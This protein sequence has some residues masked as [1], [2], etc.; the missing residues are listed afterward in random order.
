MRR[1]AFGLLLGSSLLFGCTP[2]APAPT[3]PAAP[4]GG[5]APTSG[6]TSALNAESGVKLVS[7][8][9]DMHCPTGCY[10]TVK[11]TLEEIA[12]VESV[13]LAEQKKEGEID[14]PKVYIK[15]NGPFD[16]SQAIAALA[17]EGFK[18][19]EVLQ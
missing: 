11:K 12:G 16:A 5:A 17:K 4:A 14:N 15:V 10:P 3:E 9:V 18:D 2:P 7:M 6:T 19:S 13:T 1:F 8:K